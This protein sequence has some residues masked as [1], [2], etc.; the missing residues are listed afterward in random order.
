ME[1][2]DEASS[3]G[4]HHHLI[5]TAMSTAITASQIQ[6]RRFAVSNCFSSGSIG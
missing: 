5:C 4:S 6:G 1:R 2:Y 3:P